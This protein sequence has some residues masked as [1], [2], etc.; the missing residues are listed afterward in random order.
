MKLISCYIEGFGKLRRRR[1]DFERGLTVINEENGFGKTT[2]SAFIKAMLYGLDGYKRSTKEFCDRQ[3]Y[4]PFDGGRFGG[5]LT[6]EYEGEEYTVTRFFGEKSET[7]DTLSVTRRGVETDAL[8]ENIGE[9]LLGL[10]RRSFE[11]VAFIRAEDTEIGTTDTVNRLLGGVG[12]GEEASFSKAVNILDEAAKRYKKQKKADAKISLTEKKISDYRDQIRDLRA[13]KDSL[14]DKYRELKRISD[15]LS[16]NN[17]RAVE[18]QELGRQLAL[19][20]HCDSE[21]ASIAERQRA[22]SALEAKYPYGI[23][24]EDEVAAVRAALSR[25]EALIAKKEGKALTGDELLKLDTLKKIFSRGIPSEGELYST[26][27]KIA[28]L[29]RLGYQLEDSAETRL[30]ESEEA[31]VKK[32]SGREPSEKR[33]SELD[34]AYSSYTRLSSEADE[35][36][37]YSRL[38]EREG[39]PKNIILY[40]VAALVLLSGALLCFVNA[41]VGAI[42]LAVGAALAAV[43]MALTPRRGNSAS[44]YAADLLARSGALHDEETR[45]NAVLFE[46]GYNSEAGVRYNYAAFREGLC[47]YE[48]IG[49]NFAL[50]EAERQSCL[51]KRAVISGELS[52]YFARYALSSDNQRKNL[53][54]LRS[55]INIYSTLSE[56][57]HVGEREGASLDAELSRLDG[58]IRG[59]AESFGRRAEEHATL[60]SEIS[61][62]GRLRGE[63]LSAGEALRK[64]KRENR[65]ADTRPPVGEFESVESLAEKR[66]ALEAAKSRLESEISYDEAIA[67]RLERIEG[68]YAVEQEKLEEYKK[69]YRL[70]TETKKLLE[71]AES[72]L[73]ERYVKP[74]SD[75]FKSLALPLATVLGEGVT[76]TSDYELKLE[77]GGVLRSD[78]HLSTGEGAI[79]MLCYRLALMK[80]IYSGSKIFC[81]LDDPFTGLDSDKMRRVSELLRKLSGDMQIIYFTCHESRDIAI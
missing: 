27:G 23:P 78:K 71:L 12:D 60:S 41:L 47:R 33:L 38:G 1:F 19:Y 50:W 49:R 56:R 6:L 24:T 3:K 45:I 29:E 81:I 35:A 70:L 62:I 46:Y 30:S 26:E 32:F 72:S 13:V 57:E 80:N 77:R 2:L 48:E 68:E 58:S 66:A 54:D 53:S 75:S 34:R 21:E 36:R 14:P 76:L 65:L 73:K 64:F 28:E 79:A 20:A 43:G 18:S 11:R 74:L 51:A 42:V 17:S 5:N 22:L 37:R 39:R 59:F 55:L 7:E 9:R 25:R 8:G 10:D 31:L 67:E 63:I 16:E 61:D 69:T 40:F 4:Y 15:K 52:D 44:Q